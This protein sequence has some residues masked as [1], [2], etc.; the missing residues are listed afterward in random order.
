MVVARFVRNVRQHCQATGRFNYGVH[1]IFTC[2]KIWNVV[3]RVWN[4]MAHAQ[5]PDFVFQR[6]ERVHLN[7]RGASVQS[8]TVSRGVR[9]S[10]SNAGYTMFRGSVKST[11]YPL[12]SPVSLHFPSS[13]SPCAITFQLDSTVRH[14]AWRMFWVW[15]LAVGSACDNFSWP[16]G[17]DH[18]FVPPNF[19][20]G[21][22][23]SRRRS[24]LPLRLFLPSHVNISWYETA[25][26]GYFVELKCSLQHITKP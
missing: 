2:V 1:K 21:S 22:T 26:P 24:K 8:A 20:W 10:G 19:T 25:F 17:S 11:G 15:H 12:H 5:K 23:L 14:V 7:R 16:K 6:N 18:P 3:D 4:V 13:A 9:I